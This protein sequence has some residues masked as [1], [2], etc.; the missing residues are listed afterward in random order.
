MI[1]SEKIPLKMIE[2]ISFLSNEAIRVIEAIEKEN[3]S[4]LYEKYGHDL[5]HIKSCLLHI[6][7][8]FDSYHNALEKELKND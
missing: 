6:R 2:N 1:I 7:M 8:N 3:G 5:D 4:L